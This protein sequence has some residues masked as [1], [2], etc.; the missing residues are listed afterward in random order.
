MIF[1]DCNWVF[2]MWQWSV[3]IGKRE[4]R[5]E[6]IGRRGRGRKQLLDD[7][8]EKRGYWKSKEEALDRRQ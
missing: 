2:T 3:H 5:T 4:G 1:T 8:K 7:V 6:V